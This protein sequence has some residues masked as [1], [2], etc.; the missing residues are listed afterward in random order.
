MYSPHSGYPPSGYPSHSQN[1]YPPM[2]SHPCASP[3]AP[4]HHGMYIYVFTIFFYYL[5][6]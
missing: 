1:V 3:Y 6:T 5:M 2:S 4:Q